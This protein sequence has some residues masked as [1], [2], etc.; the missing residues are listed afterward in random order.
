MKA[1]TTILG[2][3]LLFIAIHPVAANAP[4]RTPEQLTSVITRLDS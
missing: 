2:A 4:A 1:V 3:G